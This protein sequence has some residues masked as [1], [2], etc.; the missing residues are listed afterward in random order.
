[1]DDM[2]Q[3]ILRHRRFNFEEAAP[4]LREYVTR[5]R[6]AGGILPDTVL[7]ENYDV[8][9]CR[10]RYVQLDLISCKRRAE[11]LTVGENATSATGTVTTP[12]ATLSRLD[13]NFYAPVDRRGACGAG[14]ATSL[15]APHGRENAVQLP[16]LPTDNSTYHAIDS[17]D[18]YDEMGVLDASALRQRLLGLSAAPQQPRDEAFT[19]HQVAQ[20][21]QMAPTLPS[22]A[23]DLGPSL[24]SASPMAAEG[25]VVGNDCIMT[26]GPSTRHD[27][28]F[29]R[30]NNTCSNTATRA[31]V[32]MEIL[33][34][35]L[36]ARSRLE[37]LQGR[38]AGGS[39]DEVDMKEK[40]DELR[41]LAD[42]LSDLQQRSLAW[43]ASASLADAR[44]GAAGRGASAHNCLPS[45]T[46]GTCSSSPVGGEPT[47]RILPTE[48]IDSIDL[49][50]LL[51]SLEGDPE[52]S[53]G[54]GPHGLRVGKSDDKEPPP[55]EP[56][57]AWM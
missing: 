2:L 30:N 48:A 45:H 9:A 43:Q 55:A 3:L 39:G 19:S 37:E 4:R 5:V 21:S 41:T 15:A 12:E 14:P 8:T 46:S 28:N 27:D 34:P 32:P 31:S 52:D 53:S 20:P 6:S 23:A 54:D 25:T 24:A 16:K 10:L 18:E 1:M 35:L 38:L 11:Q 56:R 33:Q 50:D 22:R 42:E 57:G 36:D 49:E 29:I 13:G 44:T 26:D 51:R 40:F 17:D 7:P 47:A